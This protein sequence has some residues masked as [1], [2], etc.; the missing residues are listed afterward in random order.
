MGAKKFLGWLGLFFFISAVCLIPLS[1]V[2]AAE[3]KEILVGAVTSLTGSS[4]LTGAEQKWAYEQ[5]VDDVNK[6]GGVYVKELG[7]KLPIKLIFAD[8]KGTPDK[9][10]EEMEKL[11]KLEK[12]DFA[13]SGIATQYNIG[14]CYRCREIQGVLCDNL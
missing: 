4:A 1:G 7:K 9:A 10:A 2:S 5:A 6:K 12:I 14:G 11:I 3:R 13:L 8:D